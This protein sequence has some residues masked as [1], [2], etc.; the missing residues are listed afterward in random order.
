MP[1][2]LLRAGVLAA[3]LVGG[4]NRPRYGVRNRH[5][6]AKFA[7]SV[8]TETFFTLNMPTVFAEGDID[9]KIR[10]MADG[11]TTGDVVWGVSFERHQ[12]DVD[13]LDSDSF[14]TEQTVTDTTS[15]TDGATV[16]TVIPFTAAQYDGVTQGDQ[17]RIRIR[18]LGTNIS[19]TMAADAQ[20][21]TV[22]IDQDA[23]PAGGGAGFFSDGGGTRA[24]IGKGS[25]APVSAGIEG[26]AHGSSASAAG[27]YSLALGKGS[28][29]ASPRGV[30]LGGGNARGLR[31]IAIGSDA[32][33]GY[34]T[35]GNYGIAIGRNAQARGLQQVSVGRQAGYGGAKDNAIAIGFNARPGGAGAIVMGRNAWVNHASGGIAIGYDVYSAGGHTINIGRDNTL[36]AGGNSYQILIGHNNT[37][38]A[39]QGAVVIGW[40]N[41]IT[42]GNS[43]VF[44]TRDAGSS[45][46]YA[47]NDR[48]V[49]IGGEDFGAGATQTGAPSECVVLRSGNSKYA[50]L[51]FR[52][53]NPARCLSLTAGASGLHS[54]STNPYIHQDTVFL[55][56][57]TSARFYGYGIHN[58]VG[59][60]NQVKVGH[61]SLRS[62]SAYNIFL[63]TGNNNGEADYSMPSG[64]AEGNVTIGR[65]AYCAREEYTLGNV[66]I[67]RQCYVFNTGGYLNYGN[68]G[69][70]RQASHKGPGRGNISMGYYCYIYND[71]PSD[72]G[73]HAGNVA[74]GTWVD[75]IHH[76]GTSHMTS[77]L[78][79]GINAKSW[80]HGHR[81][82]A[83]GGSEDIAGNA[84]PNQASFVV[85]KHETTD[86]TQTTV[87][88]YPIQADKAVAFWGWAVARRTDADGSNAAFSVGNQ[89]VYRNA[90]GG[91]TLVG[92]PA[93]WTMD[94]NQGAPAW[95]IDTVISGNNLVVRVTGTA[96]QT[97]EWVIYL[98]LVEVR[99]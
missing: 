43:A 83:A 87:I 33:G 12:V 51:Y 40:N 36:S 53:T 74:L 50:G 61:A 29:S 47:A 84:V 39:N 4:S 35:T 20:L 26:L 42:P 63:I 17:F 75:V 86:A 85:E 11:V 77:G 55:A 31:S 19:D 45:G 25:P 66:V 65:R 90:A 41:A 44:I 18:R 37:V 92:S 13:D 60:V 82:W 54:G 38:G 80:T 49:V 76:S 59:L 7:Q 46:G 52:S 68:V 6:V 62:R 57:G 88:T 64:S 73:I 78:G 56:A 98:H 48:G 28:T 32:E 67:G 71:S 1:T 91:P 9:V 3:D 81:A 8:D 14:A 99:G 58:I 93:N 72:Y 70:G 5:R 16:E 2:S 79:H 34:L 10:W 15:A 95:T 97:L 96:A 69:I 89:L 30:A 27:D 22:V 23:T 94:A 21:M 24:G